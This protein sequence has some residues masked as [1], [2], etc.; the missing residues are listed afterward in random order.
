MEPLNPQ[1][2]AGSSLEI[3]EEKKPLVSVTL[4]VHNNQK[5]LEYAV[6]S[7][8]SQTFKDFELIIVDDGSTDRTPGII[9]SFRDKR[10]RAF[11]IPH[12]GLPRAR[13][14]ALAKARAPFLAVLDSDD[15]WHEEKLELQLDFME[16]NQGIH[17][18]ATNAVLIDING[19]EVG[20]LESPSG[21]DEIRERLAQKNCFVHSS[22]LIRREPMKDSL[23]YRN[24]FPSAH[25]Y[26]L[27]LRIMD[28]GGRFS[29]LDR[30][31]TYYRI[32]PESIS[33][34]KRKAQM[35][36]AKAARLC[37]L[38][39]ISGEK[40]VMPAP[41]PGSP[42]RTSGDAHYHLA[43]S[44]IF[45]RNSMTSRAVESSLKA[46]RKSPFLFKAWAV[47]V[48]C[49]LPEGLRRMVIRKA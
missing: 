37:H 8:L 30:F 28:N 42:G 9:K 5:Y 41:P 7:V 49:M 13:N 45:L 3:I 26:D 17:V 36:F 32:S 19:E 47:L 16:R 43:L 4:V 35:H 6:D 34:G 38:M 12:L 39:R 2:R 33:I 46:I 22:I 1:E 44:G 21:D 25:D 23:F 31:L 24:E 11:R 29:C 48:L 18:L 15:L 40:E 27:W 20:R 14:N 10:V